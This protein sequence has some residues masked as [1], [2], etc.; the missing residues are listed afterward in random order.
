MI[1]PKRLRII[2]LVAARA[3]RKVAVRLTW[4]T[5]SQSSSRN[6]TKRLSRVM[7]A[8]A[9]R[10]STCPI[11][12]SAAGTSASTSA[13]SERLHGSTWT[14]SPSLPAKESSTSR[15]VPEIATVAPCACRACAIAAPMPPVAPVT[16]A[17]LPVRSNIDISLR[18]TCGSKRL[19]RGGNIAWAADGNAD[20]AI[21]DA[22]NQ[23][24][25]HLAGADLEKPVDAVASHIADG[26]APTHRPG[27]LF[28]QAAAN[29]VGIGE[30]RSQHVR[31]QWHRRRFD[32]DARQ[33]LRHRIGCR[34]HQLA[35]ERRRHRQQHGALGASGFRD[36]HCTIDRGLI[37]G[38]HHLTAAIVVG[39]L[40]NLTL[41]GLMGDRRR[42]F[43]VEAEQGRHRAGADSYRLLPGT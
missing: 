28:D 40:T 17:I 6:C 16:S 3:R 20:R 5:S 13:L 10:M 15:R 23:A 43:V 9:I 4:M 18:R 30:R 19:F 24:A 29:L 11:A 7:P 22:L 2:S 39:G 1:R 35:M 34:L 33:R 27:D 41:G 42:R 8:L 25:Q 31:Y 14:R 21:C 38:D 36:L 32:G 26:L 37:T 12:A